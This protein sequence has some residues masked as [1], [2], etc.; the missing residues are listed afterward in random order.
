MLDTINDGNTT[1]SVSKEVLGLTL[2]QRILLST[3]LVKFTVVT[4]CAV[5]TF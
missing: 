3:C 4:Q 5:R 2:H 1:G